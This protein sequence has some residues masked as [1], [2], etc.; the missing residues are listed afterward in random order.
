MAHPGGGGGKRKRG[1]RSYTGEF[2]TDGGF[3]PSQYRAGSN[4]NDH[5]SNNNNNNNNSGSNYPRDIQAHQHQQQSSGGISRDL[6]ERGRGGGNIGGG[7]GG[8]SAGGGRRG[9]RSR[10]GL[11]RKFSE[12]IHGQNQQMGQIQQIRQTSHHQQT[13]SRQQTPQSLSQPHSQV[14][15]PRSQQQQQRPASPRAQLRREPSDT[16]SPSHPT[17]AQSAVSLSSAAESTAM[18]T[19]PSSD[20]PMPPPAAPQVMSQPSTP[21]QP[22]RRVASY[23]FEHLTD[24]CLSSWAEGRQ[25]VLATSRRACEGDDTL[26]LST[27]FQE[28]IQSVLAG[29]IPAT[30]G[31]ILIKAIVGESSSQDAEN[32]TNSELSSVFLDT[33]SILTESEAGPNQVLRT[34]VASTGI[35]PALMRRQLDSSLLQS[36]GM[37]R[38]TFVRMGI[39]K[40]TNL[41]YRQSNY[42]LLREESEGYSKLLT[43]LFTT[44]NNEAPSSEVVKDT[45]ERVKAMIGAFDM[46]V[47]R[48]L[49]VTL[50][51]F[52]AVLVKQ[53]RFFVKFLRVSSWWPRRCSSAGYNNAGETGLPKWALPE[54]GGWST[55]EEDRKI[56]LKANE[57]RDRQ[58][59]DR[60]REV[61]LPAFFEIGRHRADTGR[62]VSSDNI[63]VDN[64]ETR[65]W[66]EQ[67]G[68]TPPRGNR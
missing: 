59:W 16:S 40:Q 66:I 27:I 45:F 4:I 60:V 41:L 31:G 30:E 56:A 50:D 54:S 26:T 1:D 7:R 24:Q 58:F 65:A 52:A 34:F 12:P 53:Y 28:V 15:T 62:S 17:H 51:V 10:N 22:S 61:G 47:G 48:V 33:L 68:V 55:T 49:D 39:R 3:R 43:E 37:I 6:S 19:T 63:A 46:D 67:T 36:L 64:E 20:M 21:V 8:N 13:P 32:P 38:D 11:S 35:S 29:R 23:V 57:E 18:I 2:S 25:H 5:S 14:Q 9:N 42:N 44:S